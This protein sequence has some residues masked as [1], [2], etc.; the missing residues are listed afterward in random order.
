MCPRLGVE[1]LEDRWCPSASY[2]ITDLGTLGGVYSNANAINTNGQVVGASSTGTEGHPYLWTP[3]G[4]N[5][6][7]SNPQMLDL[8]T[9]GGTSGTA[10][11]INAAGWVAGES[12]TA[13]GEDH[14]FLWT[15][16]GTNG[17]P[18][19]PQMLDLSGT[20]SVAFGINNATAAHGVQVVGYSQ[21][22]GNTATHAFLWEAGQMKDLGTLGGT[23]SQALGINDAGQVTGTARLSGDTVY[24]AFLWTPGGTSGVPSNPQMQDLG[25]LGGDGSAGRA[26]NAGGQVV[27]QSWTSKSVYHAFRW[28]PT[29]PNGTTGKMTDLGTF[30]NA[31]YNYSDAYGINDSG[32]VVGHAEPPD[33]AFYWPGKGSIQDLNSQIPSNSGWGLEIATGIN[34][35]GQIVGQGQLPGGVRHGFLLTPTSG[36][37]LTAAATATAPFAEV[38]SQDQVVLE[39][40]V[41]HLLGLDHEADGVLAETLTAG[42]RR[43]PAS[44]AHRADLA[45]AKAAW[46]GIAPTG[47]HLLSCGAVPR[48]VS[49]LV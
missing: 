35:G 5:G 25:T 36:K 1:P 23:W 34:N 14:A 6:V 19:N 7:P 37:A 43:V 2:S 46:A 22:S 15:P 45:A 41:G 11:A 13:G 42:S 48:R 18:S 21:L 30:H 8:G 26:I 40:E 27:G 28:A 17:V 24:H 10:H 31:T 33:L 16:G 44:A 39:H 47:S 38:L 9:L 12:Y 20:S 4:T 29:S 49:S 32:Y 3:G